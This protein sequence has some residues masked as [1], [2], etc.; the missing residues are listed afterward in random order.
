MKNLSQPEIDALQKNHVQ[1][2]HFMWIGVRN[3]Q[4]ASVSHIGFWSGTMAVEAEC[5]PVYSDT[6]VMRKWLAM[7]VIV[8]INPIIHTIGISVQPLSVSLSNL[9]VSAEYILRRDDLRQGKFELYVGIFDP[10]TARLVAPA[11]SLFNGYIDH[12]EVK[13][14]PEGARGEPANSAMVLTCVS[15]MQEAYRDNFAKRSDGFQRLRGANDGFRQDVA[16]VGDW[17]IHWG[18]K[19][20]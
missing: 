1:L 8:E 16:V 11:R 5:Q 14:T 2:R 19:G 18:Q 13:T 15:E 17:A 6:P 9:P 4:D 3:R 12:I 20:T 7:G 10:D